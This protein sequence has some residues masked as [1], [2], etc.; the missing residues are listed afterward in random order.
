MMFFAS[1]KPLTQQRYTT[2][3][4]RLAWPFFC[5]VLFL[6]FGCVSSG[7]NAADD[8]IRQTSND[9]EDETTF[10]VA[11]EQ[12]HG[13]SFQ[14]TVILLTHYSSQGAT[15]LTINR[16]TDI[17][18]NQ[19]LPRIRHLQNRTDPLYL[20]GP[21]NPKTIF[22]LLRTLQPSESMHRISGNVYFAMGRSNYTDLFKS[23]SAKDIR[24]YAGYAGWAAGQLQK[25]IDRGDW[26][27][28]HTRPDIIFED[29]NENLWYRLTK[30]WSGKWI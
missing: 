5:G 8:D 30:R 21:V 23:R 25:E 7:A 6:L 29:D 1:T 9:R 10:L 24:T 12:L 28:I 14:Q 17:P 3:G 15:G 2:K 11:T 22:I 13:T 19:V 16:P 27:M 18:L 20:G 26:L 4:R